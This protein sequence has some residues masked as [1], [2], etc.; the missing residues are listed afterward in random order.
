MAINRRDW[1]KHTSFGVL[2]A[3]FVKERVSPVSVA[4]PKI[5]IGQI[6][7]KHGHAR[8][9]MRMVVRQSSPVH[10]RMRNTSQIIG[11]APVPPPPGSACH[12][13]RNSPFTVACGGTSNSISL[14]I[15]GFLR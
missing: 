6:G 14:N 3:P 15:G 8:S 10:F 4:K 7:T 1:L 11:P 13:S 2:A 9:K 5:K 12:S